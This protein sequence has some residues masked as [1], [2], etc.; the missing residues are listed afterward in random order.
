MEGVGQGVGCGKGKK[1]SLGLII[2]N[3][4]GEGA[5]FLY[6]P[7]VRV[8]RDA[9][10]MQKQKK[11]NGRKRCGRAPSRHLSKGKARQYNWRK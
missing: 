3:R 6:V 7:Q 2:G 5:I 4:R 11:K 1:E 8:T 9:R 10:K